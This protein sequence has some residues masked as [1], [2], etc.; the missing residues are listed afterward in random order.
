MRKISFAAGCAA[1]I[2]NYTKYAFVP[3]WLILVLLLVPIALTTI[4]QA[5]GMLLIAVAGIAQGDIKAPKAVRAFQTKR[6]Q[7]KAMTYR[8]EQAEMMRKR[9]EVRL[10]DQPRAEYRGSTRQTLQERRNAQQAQTL[11]E[12]RNASTSR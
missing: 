2:L 12:R 10:G 4:L 6:I 5:L 3:M 7:K 11:Q 9:R 1:L 8:E